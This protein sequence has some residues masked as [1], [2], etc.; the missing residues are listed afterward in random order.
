MRL[1]YIGPHDGVEVPLPGGREIV[2][3][4]GEVA[5]V[6]PDE[7]AARMLD[8]PSNWERVTH[9]KPVKGANEKGGDE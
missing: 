8:Q 5:D 9:T 7:Y 1:K 6:T 2:V 4:R 3:L